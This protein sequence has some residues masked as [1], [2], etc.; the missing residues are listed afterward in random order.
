M[1]RKITKTKNGGIEQKSKNFSTEELQETEP[2]LYTVPDLSYHIS[3]ELTTKCNQDCSICSWSKV[4]D[5]PADMPLELLKKTIDSYLKMSNN[6]HRIFIGG[7]GEPLLYPKLFD[8]LSYVKKFP[9]EVGLNTNCVAL[10]DDMQSMI[11]TSGLDFLTL[12][13][14]A[15]SQASHQL[16]S[17]RDYYF[18]VKEN[19]LGI[20]DKKRKMNTKKPHIN[21]QFIKC[22]ATSG[23]EEEFHNYWKNKINSSDTITSRFLENTGGIIESH[24]II[25]LENRYPC[26]FL[27]RTF[28]IQ[29][30]GSIF[31]CCKCF[32]SRNSKTLYL[33][34]IRDIS[35]CDIIDRSK[36]DMMK[37]YHLKNNYS[38][39]PECIKCN[40]FL[41]SPKTH[42]RKLKDGFK[43]NDSQD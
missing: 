32:F 8:A 17:G 7:L 22:E 37:N 42:W 12:S 24:D 35:F 39:I 2:L 13:L 34:N 31:P 14:N 20:L 27:W 25:K 11:L 9:L 6:M 36:L 18:K 5:K 28:A 30:D 1:K 29:V 43:I 15:F 19:I 4:I 38:K 21:L 3:I 10:D 23:E 26:L 33:G 40:S 16:L 41:A